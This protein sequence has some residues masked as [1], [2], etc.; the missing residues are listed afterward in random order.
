MIDEASLAGTFSLDEI[1]GAA[2]AAGAKILLLGDF[3]QTGSVEAGGAFSLLAKDRGDLVAELNE[4]RRFASEWEKAASI[5]LRLGTSSAIASY[6]ANG[7]IRTGERQDLLDVIY[8]AWRV[9]VGAGKASLMIAGD[10][11][12]VFELNARARAGRVAEG[13]V[14]ATGLSIAEGQTAGVGDEIVT[15]KNNRMLSVG[16]SWVKNGDRFLVTSTNADGTMGVRRSPGGPEVLLPAD[17][18]A[19]HVELAYATTAYRSQGRTTDT[20][21][22]LVSPT[23]TREVLYVAATRGRESN[24]IY[25]DTSFDPDPDTGHDNLSPQQSA[26]E[27]LACVLANEGADL[28]AHESLELAQRRVEDFAVLAA[29]YETLAAVALQQRFDELLARSGFA[30]NHLERIRQ[31]PSYGPLLAALRDAE[32]RGL[33]LN[34]HFPE[35]VAARGFDGAEDP[36]SVV[37][38]RVRRWAETAGSN[39]RPGVKLVAGLIPRALGVTDPDMARAL[40]ERENT[41]QRRARELA[42]R[43]VAEGQA[44]VSSLGV[45]PTDP[46]ERARWMRAVTTVAAYR[47][48]WNIPV[49][50]IPLGPDNAIE[51]VEALR[52]R[53]RARAATKLAIRL[54]GSVAMPRAEPNHVIEKQSFQ[55]TL[56]I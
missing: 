19:S 20:S 51:P 15:R 10:A 26:T 48:R 27:V 2:K 23:T 47:E 40:D 5:E 1:V 21:H 22:T 50:H 13:T 49:G 43:A 34:R 18:V 53:T 55:P 4:V 24:V 52:D 31:S 45:P 39:R 12:A 56:T 38:E 46:I 30:P 35:L 42:E 14:A 32:S 11:A 16:K 25:V 6:E 3:A 17:F 33:D 44:W 29:E 41:M 54:S 36:A 7:R 37:N 28:S 8:A 9:D